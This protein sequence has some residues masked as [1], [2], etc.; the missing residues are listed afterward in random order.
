MAMHL[1]HQLRN[2]MFAPFF[3]NIISK[4]LTV[5]RNKE[6]KKVSTSGKGHLALAVF[7]C[8]SSPRASWDVLG[9]LRMP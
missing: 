9:C 7:R 4:N 2:D 1:S 5:S 3:L 8:F 6:V